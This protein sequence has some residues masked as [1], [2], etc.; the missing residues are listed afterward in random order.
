MA[1]HALVGNDTHPMI[2]AISRALLGATITGALS[3]FGIWQTTDE[4]KILISAGVIPFLSYLGA[5]VGLEGPVDSWKAR[6]KK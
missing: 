1:Y 3:F 5:R 2:V 6:R 4:P